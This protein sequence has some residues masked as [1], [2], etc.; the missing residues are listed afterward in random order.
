MFTLNRSLRQRWTQELVSPAKIRRL[1]PNLPQHFLSVE[2]SPGL[3]NSQWP[4]IHREADSSILVGN[5]LLIIQ[6]V[7]T[8]HNWSPSMR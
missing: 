6:P 4:M 2:L 5:L 7:P 3:V 1:Q 8:S